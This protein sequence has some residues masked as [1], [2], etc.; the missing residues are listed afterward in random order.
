MLRAAAM[1]CRDSCSMRGDCTFHVCQYRATSAGVLG[2][3]IS[4]SSPSV[5]ALSSNSGTMP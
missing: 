3:S 5:F 1:I 4:T 2:V